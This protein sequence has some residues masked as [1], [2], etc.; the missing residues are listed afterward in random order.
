MTTSES[1]KKFTAQKSF[2]T[3]AILFIMVLF[4]G[5]ART[6]YF[7][8]PTNLVNVL[9]QSSINA[10]LA[11]GVTFCIITG[12][13]DLSVGSILAVS[14]VVVAKFA[15]AGNVA[16]GILLALVVGFFMGAING[17]L[18]IKLKLVPFIATLA[19]MGIGRGIVLIISK[20]APISNM[21]DSIRYIGRGRIVGVPVPV[22]LMVAMIALGFY[23][24]TYTKLGRS[25]YCVGGNVE[26]TRLSGIN[27]Q[28]VMFSAHAWSG[29]MAGLAGIVMT[30][31]LNSA[32]PTAGDGY[33]LDA[34]A[35]S[36]IGGVS[37]AGGEGTAI[38]VFLGALIMGVLRNGLNL[39]NVSANWQR[40]AIGLVLILAMSL[41]TV[42]GSRKKS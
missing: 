19:M 29:L 37:L 26:A 41:D 23:I 13:I 33:E 20:G 30:A 17:L 34:I 36:V 39:M 16:V 22:L 11:I 14:G 6:Q 18:V 15:V 10:I 42:G 35:A 9:L 27:V 5:I 4:L 25:L 24:L 7:L 31:R 1:I 28:K 32:Q 38:G 2:V 21:P 8:Q 3:F 12:G 40:V